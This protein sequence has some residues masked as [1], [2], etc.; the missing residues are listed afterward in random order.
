[1]QLSAEDDNF[2]T[3]IEGAWWFHE[4]CWFWFFI[5]ERKIG[6]WL[7]NWIRPNIGVTGGG[8]WVWD[9]TTH[10]HWEVPYY[11]N[12][13]NLRLPAERDLRDFIFPSGTSVKM[14]E[15]L[16]AYQ[17]R[18]SDGE[19][20]SL[21]LEYRAVMDPWVS[22][23]EDA[24][25]VI[26]ANHFDQVGRVRGELKLHGE[27][28]NVDCLAIRDRTWTLRSERWREGGGYGYTNAA[29]DSGEAF[30][31]VGTESL[32]G[33]LALNGERHA[34]VAGQRIVERSPE[35]GQPL[36]VHVQATDAAGR[37]LDATGRRVSTMLMPIPG[38]HALVWTSLMSWTI[39]GLDAWGEDQEPWPIASW[40]KFRRQ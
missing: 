37:E 20:I 7:Y 18:H 8:C 16:S 34:I 12:Y 40:S 31:A 14:L 1:M 35:N 38:V 19:S 30:L 6:G 24:S 15:P 2:H 36:V 28:M 3:P 29:A 4:T 27:R 33:Y 10:L 32:R 17:L 25:G 39:N 13:S 22:G 9:E 23:T 5:P 11:A 21:D 26:R